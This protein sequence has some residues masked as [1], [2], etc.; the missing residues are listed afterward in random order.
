[1]GAIMLDC[2]LMRFPNSGLYHYCLNLGLHVNELLAEQGQSK[3]QFYVPRNA[4]KSFDDGNKVIV[5]HKYHRF[6]KPFL[7]DCKIWHAPFQSGRIIP[8][9]EKSVRVVLTIHDLNVLHEQ[10]SVK[11]QRN[12]IAKTQQ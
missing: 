3:M 8:Q 12:S 7:L 4:K 10:K 11:E 5:E 6:F 1:M 2:D 9:R